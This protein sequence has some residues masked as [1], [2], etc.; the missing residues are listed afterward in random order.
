MGLSSLDPEKSNDRREDDSNLPL[1]PPG[2]QLK[3]MTA[4]KPAA[5]KNLEMKPIRIT[6]SVLKH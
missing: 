4:Q 5:W 2:S 1:L 6:D 3:H